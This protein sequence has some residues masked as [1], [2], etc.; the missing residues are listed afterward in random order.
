MPAPEQTG[1]S[2]V[3]A[4]QI[5]KVFHCL[6]HAIIIILYVYSKIRYQNTPLN[7]KTLLLT[8][9]ILFVYGFSI[10]VLQKYAIVN[11]HFDY[12][13]IAA[14]T[15]GDFIGLLIAKYMITCSAN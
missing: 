2:W 11:R 14:N 6:S 12:L 8:F 15:L 13:D 3:Q 1:F 4:F 7:N 10:E 9:L 5:D